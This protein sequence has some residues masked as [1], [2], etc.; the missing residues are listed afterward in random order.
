MYMQLCADGGAP[1][2]G[3]WSVRAA[4]RQK[5]AGG[6]RPVSLAEFGDCAC[7]RLRKITRKVTQLF[8]RF[9]EPAGL[10]TTQF[11]LLGFIDWKDRIAIGELAAVMITDPTTLTRNLRPL[12]KL[13]YVEII[14]DPADRRR[15]TIA[16][17]A[18]GA[19]VLRE[20]TPLW[21]QA[22]A[23]IVAMVGEHRALALKSSLDQALERL[24][25]E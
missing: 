1:A 14:A 5:R 25:S 4:R 6:D 21:R 7:L 17:T 15:R 11:S 20:A 10:T 18:R 12:V 24:G 3:G 23:R 13:G 22:Q 16:L 2:W 9:L 19:A 8:D